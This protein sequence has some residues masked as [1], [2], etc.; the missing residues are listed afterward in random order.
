MNV[1]HS[2]LS[3]FGAAAL[4]FFP[5]GE[6]LAQTKPKGERAQRA[7]APTRTM[8]KLQA[9]TSLAPMLA[10]VLPGVVSILITG[11]RERPI[12]IT[13]ATSTAGAMA[14][15]AEKEPFRS[16]GSGVIV[17]A[18]RGIIF[19][20]DHVVA[21]ATRID[22]A[23]SDG[24]IVEAKLL[25]TDPATDVAVLKIEEKNLTAVPFGNSDDLRIGDFIAAVGNPFGLEGSASQGI[26]SATMRTDIGYEIFEDFIQV[27]AAVN[28]G[29]SGG[30][31]VDIDGRLVGINT[32]TGAAKL[33][34]Q[35]I[36]FAI[37]INMARRIADELIAKGTFRRGSLGFWTQDLNYQMAREMNLP[38]TRGAAVKSVVPASPAARA[39]LK[40][41][42]VI[43]G[44]AG[45]AV[46]GQSDYVA[47]V[48]S[49][50]IGREIKVS[51]LSDG[52]PKDVILSVS[53]IAIEPK[54]ELPQM[55]LTSLKGLSLGAMLPGFRSFGLVQGA[56]V[57]AVS[58]GGPLA[59]SGL[60]ADDVITK[61][62]NATVR[63][64]QDVFDAASS[65]MARYRLE[66]FRNGKTLWIYIDA[67]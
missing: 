14:E 9:A 5:S 62:D 64:P 17:D 3:A 23:V 47:R 48:A 43:V 20:N 46:R 42:D 22:V 27:D 61:V 8:S 67:T 12:T 54:A 44:L 49:S 58:P 55:S 30:A 21:N 33:R 11:E 41:G 28:P 59:R 19:T 50:P 40:A 6:A 4:L 56:R 52:K 63:T 34:T 25:G 53:D 37:P 13:P 1:S 65:K 35:G 18:Q 7:S 51:L 32:A 45:T 39:G 57:L 29:N 60:E 26:V 15:P 31:L 38:V 36:A 24:R 10:R 16:G 66:V 2:F